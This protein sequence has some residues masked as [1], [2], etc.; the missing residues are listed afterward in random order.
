MIKNFIDFIKESEDKIY[1]SNYPNKFST[2]S[3]AIT[4]A[5][6]E[7]TYDIS[8][9]EVSANIESG[10]IFIND[11]P[12]C[13]TIFDNGEVYYNQD[14]DVQFKVGDIKNYDELVIS[15]KNNVLNT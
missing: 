1:Q 11:N 6:F 8:Q 15:L 12:L 10:N 3:Q 5:G 4:E 9:I 13:F 14:E 7:N 2:L